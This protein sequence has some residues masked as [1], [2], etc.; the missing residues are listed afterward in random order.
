MLPVLKAPTDACVIGV[1]IGYTDSR[2]RSMTAGRSLQE[3]PSLS[4]EKSDDQL[5]SLLSKIEKTANLSQ[6][7]WKCHQ[8]WWLTLQNL[9]HLY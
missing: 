7:C 4:G 1:W 9:Q 2:I 8:Y 3:L 5:I 6:N